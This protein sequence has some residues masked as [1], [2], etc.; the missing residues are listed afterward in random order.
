MLELNLPALAKLVERLDYAPC[1][2]TVSGAH[3]YGFPSPDSDVDL[4]GCHQLALE[5]V[6]GLSLPGETSERQFDLHGTEVDLVS[7]D[8]GKYFRLLVRNNGY[9]LE[10]I[11]SPLVVIG[12]EFLAE[13]RPLAQRCI[14]RHHYHHYRGFF[15]TQRRMLEREQPRRVKS[16]LYA[17]RVL[18]TGI[19]LLRT[20]E[21]EAHLPRLEEDYR[22]GFIQELI[23]AKR[24]E[25]IADPNLDWTFHDAELSRL[26]ARLE[27][28][29][30]ASRLPEERDRAGVNQLLVSKRLG[31]A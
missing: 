8:L 6:V 17:Y 19:H 29:Y 5:D 23:A 25:K 9:V 4:R 20:G 1:F 27:S 14:T 18:L 28:E 7:H 11:F 12:A 16:L 10:Q 13:L 21:V 30:Q 2:V 22:L 3:L 31:Q 24:A 26:E 15:A